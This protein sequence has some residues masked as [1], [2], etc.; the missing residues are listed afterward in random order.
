MFSI[1]QSSHPLLW[2]PLHTLLVFSG[3]ASG[4]LWR[5]VWAT[6]GGIPDSVTSKAPPHRH[7]SAS[8][9]RGACRD[10]AFT[11]SASHKDTVGGSRPRIWTHQTG[12]YWSNVQSLCFLTQTNVSVMVPQQLVDHRGL[13][14]RSL[15]WTGDAEVWLQ[16]FS[17]GSYRHMDSKSCQIGL[18]SAFQPD[19]T[20]HLMLPAPLKGQEI[21]QIHHDKARQ[22]SGNH[23]RW[24]PH[25]V[26]RDKAK[27][28]QRVA[29]LRTKQKT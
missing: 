11:F 14:S 25:K 15:L 27:G 17:L 18:S 16:R 10:R 22:W 4:G 3:W 2:S 24:P 29:T 7:T 13:I 26:H 8:A 5:C 12:F 19:N 1:L 23:F 28:Q 21:P 6:L 9:L 20:T